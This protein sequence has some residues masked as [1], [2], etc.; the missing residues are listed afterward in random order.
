MQ[1][2]QD[3]RDVTLGFVGVGTINKSM[4]Q[5]L[6]NPDVGDKRA[7]K[8]IISPRNK[9]NAEQLASEF[10]DILK[11][12]KTNQEVVDKADWVI[13]GLRV[14]MIEKIVSEL[15]F[16][17]NQ[18]I[19][20]LAAMPNEKFQSCVDNKTCTIVR[21]CPLP[22]MA[23]NVGAPLIQ[24]HNE[25]VVNLFST[26]G[27]P[28][29]VS[30]NHEMYSMQGLA[31]LMGPQYG[32]MNA[33]YEWLVEQDIEKEVAKQYTVEM[34]NSIIIDALEK[35]KHGNMDFKDMI[36]EQSK[37]GLNEANHQF[38]ER[39]HVYDQ[40]K[41]TLENTYNK[42]NKNKQK[43]QQQTVNVLNTN[44][45]QQQKQFKPKIQSQPEMNSAFF[46]FS[47][48]SKYFFRK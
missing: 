35:V 22:S 10:P 7:K 8:I 44:Q 36:N 42:M 3:Y 41:T 18:L 20:N 23:L 39:Q 38:M 29:V 4:I 12:A 32:I 43:Q 40:F 17:D 48:I 31:C 25:S 9:E 15:K 19:V 24:P 14:D 2:F 26:V 45:T 27:N 13:V 6:C 1:E 5:G 47:K 21:S 16:K 34:Y 33:V 30:S 46:K 11:I 28:F 37:G